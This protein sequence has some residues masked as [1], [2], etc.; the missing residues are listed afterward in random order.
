MYA[1]LLSLQQPLLM[2]RCNMYNMCKGR[3]EW[4]DVELGTTHCLASVVLQL[5][6]APLRPAPGSPA[7][8]SWNFWHHSWGRLTLLAG[9]A[10]TIIGALLVHD[11]KEIPYLHWLLPACVVLGLMSLLALCLEAFK[12]QVQCIGIGCQL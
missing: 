11:M 2:K 4:Q 9:A 5:L 10:N 1:A 7:R 6:V 8:S 3:L 12:M